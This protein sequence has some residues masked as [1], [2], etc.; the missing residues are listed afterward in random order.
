MLFVFDQNSPG[1]IKSFNIVFLHLLLSSS[2]CATAVVRRFVFDKNSPV[3]IKNNIILYFLL[4]VFNQ[5]SPE[6]LSTIKSFNIIFNPPLKRMIEKSTW[7]VV[8]HEN[9]LK[10]V[11]FRVV[12]ALRWFGRLVCLFRLASLFA[13]LHLIIIKY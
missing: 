11:I 3:A 8:I 7:S 6:L 10:I 2:C 12:V 1:T 4:F 9:T 5:N 13:W